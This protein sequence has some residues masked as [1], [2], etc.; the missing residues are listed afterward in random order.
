MMYLYPETAELVSNK[1]KGH[2]K[3]TLSGQNKIPQ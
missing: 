3:G 2:S 1:M